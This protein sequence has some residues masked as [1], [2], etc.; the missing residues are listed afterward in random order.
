MATKFK[1]LAQQYPSIDPEAEAR[2]QAALGFQKQQAIGSAQPSGNVRAQA[3]QMGAA[4]TGASAQ[5]GATQMQN[6]MENANATGQLGL[7]QQRQAAQAELSSTGV[8]QGEGIANRGNQLAA[9]SQAGD[10]AARKQI[11]QAQIAQAQKL[12]QLGIDQDNRLNFLTI[13]Q[14]E[15]L[16][17]L[18]EDLQQELFD[19]QMKF[20]KDER[21]RAFSNERQLQDYM[22]VSAKD[23]ESLM[24]NMQQ[25]QQT[26]ERKI[27]LME[28]AHAQLKA[29]LE[30]GFLKNK[31]DL[32]NASKLRI[33]QYAADMEKKIAREKAKAAARGQMISGGI[34]MLGGAALMAIGTGLV[35]VTG[36]TS[37]VLTGAGGAMAAQGASQVGAGASNS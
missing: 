26:S 7:A 35:P 11:T 33:A 34:Q 12:N 24:D 19:N 8:A 23:E 37:L 31:Q 21:G 10:I 18:G 2:E 20:T 27:Y 32:D 29:A 4:F 3:Q 36:G 1:K 16:A 9:T 5:L 15:Q 6:R 14:R 17:A 22:I 30:R 25:M 13:K 28:A